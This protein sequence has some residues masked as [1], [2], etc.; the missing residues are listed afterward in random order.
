MNDRVG[1]WSAAS[2]WS[3]S[4]ESEIIHS[5]PSRVVVTP[6][7]CFFPLPPSAAGAHWTVGA[8][9]D[10]SQVGEGVCP[11]PGQVRHCSPSTINQRV[12][13]LRAW[14]RFVWDQQPRTLGMEQS[15]A[16]SFIS[17]NTLPLR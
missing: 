12:I 2:W 7:C 11:A 13:S 8:E 3:I 4:S 1:P 9:Q 14:A 17:K 6:S 15:D 5:T 16:D 10:Q